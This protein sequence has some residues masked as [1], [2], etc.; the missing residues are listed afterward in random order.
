MSR[1][2]D[3]E[4][5]RQLEPKVTD[6]KQIGP[7]L[8][9]EGDLSRHLVRGSQFFLLE[10]ICWAYNLASG[11]K[12]KTGGNPPACNRGAHVCAFCRKIGH[13]YVKCRNA[14]R[15]LQPKTDSKGKMN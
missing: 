2:E 8:L 14:P 6:S 12:A 10:A 4:P 13:S 7:I 11:W 5:K 15:K 3:L 1:M 9:I